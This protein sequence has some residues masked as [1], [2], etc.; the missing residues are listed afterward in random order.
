MKVTEEPGSTHSG[1]G[2]RAGGRPPFTLLPVAAAEGPVAETVAAHHPAG[3]EPHF[4]VQD[5]G[6]ERVLFRQR[7]VSC[8]SVS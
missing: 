2:T 5:P 3:P 8:R 6:Q 1:A 4:P 7:N